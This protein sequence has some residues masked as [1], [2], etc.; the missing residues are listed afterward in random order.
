M[1]STPRIR[2]QQDTCVEGWRRLEFCEGGKN[3]KARSTTR[4]KADPSGFILKVQIFKSKL[5]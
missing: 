4:S 3:M 2:V 1:P 5:V